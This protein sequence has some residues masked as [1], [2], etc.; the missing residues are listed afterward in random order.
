VVPGTEDWGVILTFDPPDVE[1]QSSNRTITLS[2][3][4]WQ[5]AI[6]LM[7]VRDVV[8]SALD[9]T[10]NSTEGWHA[11]CDGLVARFPDWLEQPATARVADVRDAFL[12]LCRAQRDKNKA[13]FEY[14]R[15]WKESGRIAGQ[16]VNRRLSGNRMMRRLYIEEL[17]FNSLWKGIPITEQDLNLHREKIKH[18]AWERARRA[19]YKAA[20]DMPRPREFKP[21]IRAAHGLLGGSSS[22]FD[23]ECQSFVRLA[24]QHIGPAERK[25]LLTKK[26][27]PVRF[28]WGNGTPLSRG[29]LQR[30]IGDDELI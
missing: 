27:Q 28:T 9:S 3:E 2:P 11:V 5:C 19:I 26:F 12:Q 16:L 14:L 13:H 20:E 17:I 15:Y 7:D 25:R 23:R 21:L 10:T 18:R 24:Q 22:R 1:E 6:D 30:F 29:E 4:E 8:L